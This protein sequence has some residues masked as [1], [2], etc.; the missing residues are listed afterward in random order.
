MTR[1]IAFALLLSTGCGQELPFR[2][3]V[4]CMTDIR[5]EVRLWESKLQH[6]AELANQIL[7]DSGILT[8]SGYCSALR[9]IPVRIYRDPW[10][11]PGS[12]S[13]HGYYNF[14]TGI[15]LTA[16]TGALLHEY[17]HA[18]DLVPGRDIPLVTPLA[19]GVHFMWKEKSFYQM[20]G[21]YEAQYIFPAH[22]SDY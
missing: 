15:E 13:Q 18:I 10:T 5:S 1:F 9:D 2:Y 8:P 14:A 20:A 22:L 6:N 11:L 3:S 12:D 21:D 7:L 4:P 17:L 16:S 19:T